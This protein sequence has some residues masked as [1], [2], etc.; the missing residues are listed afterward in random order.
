MC[1]LEK[2]VVGNSRGSV[3]SFHFVW[4]VLLLAEMVETRGEEAFVRA[5]ETMISILAGLSVRLRHVDG[6]LQL[7]LLERGKSKAKGA[8][9]EGSARGEM[10]R[11]CEV[12]GPGGES[13]PWC[14][15]LRIFEPKEH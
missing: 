8:E 5:G 4:I 11:A 13:F 9:K 12:L 2:G 10:P 1:D 3:Q 14:P 6:A 15:V 7:F